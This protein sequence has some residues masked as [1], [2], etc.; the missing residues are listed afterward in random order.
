[1]LVL[2]QQF[3]NI[4]KLMSGKASLNTTFL[5]YSLLCDNIGFMKCKL[6]TFGTFVGTSAFLQYGVLQSAV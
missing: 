6:V 4:C 1:M 3:L 5:L 2:N